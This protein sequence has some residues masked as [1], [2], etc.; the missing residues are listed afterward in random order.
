MKE[1]EGIKPV[2]PVRPTRRFPRPPQLDARLQ[3]AFDLV[4]SCHICADIGADHGKLSAVLLHQARA[5]HMLVSDVSPLALEKAKS[6]LIQQGLLAKA[7][8]TVSDGLQALDALPQARVEVVCA[9]GMGGATLAGILRKGKS[10]LQGAT[11][12]LSPQTEI[13]LL[14]QAIVQVGYSIC[15]EKLAQVAGRWYVVMQAVPATQGVPAHTRQEILLGPVL[16][17]DKPA[18]WETMLQRRQRLLQIAQRAMEEAALAKDIQRLALVREELDV[19][20]QV[21]RQQPQQ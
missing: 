12:V 16:M 3:A 10:R 9:L 18:G 5:A 1:A 11:L 4:P 14:R 21:L 19:I 17:R 8:L 2:N 20:F 6:R 15:Q 13:P 7:T